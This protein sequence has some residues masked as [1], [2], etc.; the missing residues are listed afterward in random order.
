FKNNNYI[1]SKILIHKTETKIITVAIDTERKILLVDEA[2][3][4]F[5][6][7]IS[8]AMIT[9]EYQTSTSRNTKNNG[10]GRAVVGGALAGGAGAVVGA[11]TAATTG[12]TRT[13][14]CVKYDGIKIYIAD[15]LNPILEIYAYN[16]KRFVEG[17]HATIL[18]II[19]Q[20][21]RNK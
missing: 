2:P 8:A 13:D 14:F 3:I 20:E 16:D 9:S 12:T 4:N 6:D 15:I 19:A 5:K 10:I 21:Q 18:A 11:A 7:I 17:V 1:I